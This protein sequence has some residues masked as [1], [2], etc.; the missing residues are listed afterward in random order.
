MLV[1]LGGDVLVE[2]DGKFN[3]TNDSW[4]IKRE[5]KTSTSFSKTEEYIKNYQEKENGVYYYVI[6]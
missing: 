6:V 5:E 4:S 1:F 2:D 3:Y